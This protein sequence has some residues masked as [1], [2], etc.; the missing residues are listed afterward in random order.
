M[1]IF[2]ILV[3]FLNKKKIATIISFKCAYIH[4]HCFNWIFP[5]SVTYNVLKIFV[6]S[7]FSKG[8][9][10]LRELTKM[11][12]RKTEMSFKRTFCPPTAY[13]SI[14]FWLKYLFERKELNRNEFTHWTLDHIYFAILGLR[15]MLHVFYVGD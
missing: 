3:R 14:I 1:L 5:F 10:L 12:S 6:F 7:K 2:F 9:H 4:P 11:T 13:C 15:K 8:S